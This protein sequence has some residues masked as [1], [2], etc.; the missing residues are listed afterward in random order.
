MFLHYYHYISWKWSQNNNI[1]IY[2]NNNSSSDKL[3]VYSTGLCLV[4]KV[5]NKACYSYLCFRRAV[6]AVCY[7]YL[8]T[9][10]G[11]IPETWSFEVWNLS[12]AARVRMCLFVCIAPFLTEWTSTQELHWRTPHTNSPTSASPLRLF[13]PSGEADRPTRPDPGSLPGRFLL[14]AQEGHVI[15]DFHCKAG[16]QEAG[17]LIGL[18]QRQSHSKAESLSTSTIRPGAAAAHCPRRVCG[19]LQPESFAL[20]ARRRAGKHG[21]GEG[22]TSNTAEGRNTSTWWKVNTSEQATVLG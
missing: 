22:V 16:R 1:I 13:M 5:K 4:I 2:R 6:W 19:I 21:R 20:T 17:P 3:V 15:G 7:F 14:S 10:S 8:I 11:D 9:S 18:T 12:N